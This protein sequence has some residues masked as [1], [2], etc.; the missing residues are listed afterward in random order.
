MFDISFFTESELDQLGLAKVGS[1]VQISRAVAIL[2]ASNIE[3]E[4]DVRIDA[5]SILT[6]VEGFIKIGSNVHIASYCSILGRGGVTLS[7]YSGLSHGVRVFSASDDYSGNYLTNP[8]VA[9]SMTNVS[10][11]EVFLDEHVIVGANSVLLPGVKIGKGSAVGAQSLVTKSLEP[12]GIY[13]GCPAKFL[14][15]RSTSLLELIS[16]KD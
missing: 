6:A 8:T 15:K 12:W 10:V 3:I 11:A 5:F 14:K 7:R 1:N 9:S 2:G 4:N 16:P 13:S